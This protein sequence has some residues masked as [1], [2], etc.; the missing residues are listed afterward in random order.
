MLAQ[1]HLHLARRE[2]RAFGLFLA[3]MDHL[4]QINDTP[5]HLHGDRTIADAA[6]VLRDIFRRSD[7]VA[8]LGGDEFVVLTIQS[9]AADLAAISDRLREGLRRLDDERPRPYRLSMSVGMVTIEPE[10]STS[11]DGLVER[12]DEL[13][14]EQKRRR[15]RAAGLRLST[16]PT[17]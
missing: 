5:G 15:C 10:E 14:Y 17:A 12:A 16:V 11:V 4:K 3:D 8:R 6:G 7:I 1:H 9:T 2:R 13:L